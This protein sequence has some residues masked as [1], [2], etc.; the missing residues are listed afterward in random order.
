MDS[1]ARK[2]ARSTRVACVLA[3]LLLAGSVVVNIGLLFA[4]VVHAIKPTE[5]EQFLIDTPPGISEQAFLEKFPG[6]W[7]R[8]PYIL[9][10]DYTKRLERETTNEVI[11]CPVGLYRAF[12]Y[13]GD[14]GH[15]E[16]IHFESAS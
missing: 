13:I 2:P 8:Q 3:A 11:V 12:I 1:P 9:D 16:A 5:V 4:N 15:V 6:F 10:D 7:F 14:D